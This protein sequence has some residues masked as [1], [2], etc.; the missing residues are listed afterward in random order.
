MASS[1]QP[2]ASNHQ[3]AAPGMHWKG[4]GGNPPPP[5]SRAPSLCPATISLTA[6]ARLNGICNRQQPP[7]AA[8]A[9]PSNRLPNR[10]WGRL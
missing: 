10:L 4:G 7:P 3:A 6:S 8:S 9:T 2:I 1:Q 5:N